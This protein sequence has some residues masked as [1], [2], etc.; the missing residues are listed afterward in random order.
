LIINAL[1]TAVFPLS[2]MSCLNQRYYLERYLYTP[3]LESSFVLF[4]RK[5]RFSWVL[6]FRNIPHK[7]RPHRLPKMKEHASDCQPNESLDERDGRTQLR[8]DVSRLKQLTTTT[9]D[10][11]DNEAWK[12]CTS[13]CNLEF[14]NSSQNNADETTN[15]LDED[16]LVEQYKRTFAQQERFVQSVV[17]TAAA[18]QVYGA[19][20]SCSHGLDGAL[21]HVVLRKS[22]LEAIAIAQQNGMLV[23]E[24]D[25]IRF[26]DPLLL[27]AAYSMIPE[28]RRPALHLKIGRRL[29]KEYNDSSSDNDSAPLPLI[30]QQLQQGLGMVDDIHELR[31]VAIV[32]LQAGRQAARS[33]DFATAASF[34]EQGIAAL[35]THTW[36]T[37]TYE[38]SLELHNAGAEALY[39]VGNFERMDALLD[40]VLRHA[41]SFRD[42]VQS[43][44]TLVYANGSRN[45]LVEALTTAMNVL[46]ELGEPIPKSPSKFTV[47]REY[48]RTAWMLRGKTDEYFLNLPMATN[49]TKAATMTMLS[50]VFAYGFSANPEC[51]VLAV[52][53]ILQ[54]AMKHGMTGPA[55]SAFAGYGTLLCSVFGRTDNAYRFG[56]ISV[57]L[58]GKV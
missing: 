12:A 14:T 6:D 52:F 24:S 34:F 41:Q 30:A 47:L 29:W 51:A 32:H 5:V 42:K 54:L 45:R 58:F 50:F 43:Y 9:P 2:P 39:S 57:A 7:D 15:L 33:S 55:A 56:Q 37:E 16:R 11:T 25:S 21:L 46:E 44:N 1:P 13:G 28:S 26:P 49:F 36:S 3:E 40:A 19:A 48:I 4:F 22:C 23:L 38:V 31:V 18:I 27:A 17:E 8:S 35:G 53:R 20:S 10:R